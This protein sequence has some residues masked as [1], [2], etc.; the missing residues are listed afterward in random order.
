V[1]KQLQQELE[2]KV[3]QE[4]TR[5]QTEATEKLEKHLAELQPELGEVVNKVT[6]DAL[7]QKAAQIGQVKDIAEDPKTGSLTIKVEV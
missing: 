5:L 4:Q 6:R 3:E 7:K 2:G 1:Q